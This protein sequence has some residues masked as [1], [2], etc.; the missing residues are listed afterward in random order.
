MSYNQKPHEW[1]P[2]WEVKKKVLAIE[3]PEVQAFSCFMFATGCRIG[4]ISYGYVHPDKKVTNGIRAKDVE[5]N[6]KRIRIMLP[7]FKYKK[8]KEK[9]V[10][11]VKTLESWL[12]ELLK[13]YSEEFEPNEYLFGYS[14]RYYQYKL[15]KYGW[16]YTTHS[17][18]KSRANY[19]L[20]DVNMNPRAVA[21]MLGHADLSQI[22]TYTKTPESE[23]I[24]KMEKAAEK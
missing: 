20:F 23:Y 6:R 22:M 10:Y 8:M 3:D 2:Y 15:K 7:N 9:H 17:F 13:A 21:D 14:K 18:R 1:V 16:P 12:Y 11:V 5:I 4:E 19:M 24:D